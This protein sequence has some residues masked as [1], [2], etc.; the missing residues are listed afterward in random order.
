LYKTLNVLVKNNVGLCAITTHGDGSDNQLDFWKVK[1]LIEKSDKAQVLNYED[2]GLA[3][4][5]TYHDK[6]STLVGAYEHGVLLSGINGRI[7]IISLMP[8]KG[9]EEEIKDGMNF[10]DYLKVSRRHNSIICG[11][12]SYTIADPYGPFNFFKFRLASKDDRLRIMDH[13]F[14]QVD[15]C[16]C[17]STNCAWMTISNDLLGK[18]Y[19]RV[20]KREPWYNSDAHATRRLTRNEI[21]RAANIFILGTYN[22]GDEL[23][24]K[25]REDTLSNQFNTYEGYSPSLQFVLGVALSEPPKRYLK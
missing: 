5:L 10:D 13:V 15:I 6:K 24:E 16:D 12:H 11:A 20:M 8:D 22:K 25:I 23:R 17:V 1:E 21:A 4:N 7:D 19:K 18:D 14:T 3:F 9:F 2:L